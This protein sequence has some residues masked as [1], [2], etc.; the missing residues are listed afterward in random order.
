MS[1]QYSPQG[2]RVLPT[3]I[4]N[5]I[6]INVIFSLATFAFKR[7][8]GVDL[9]DYLGLY[10]FK[11]ENFHFFQYI[12]Y[13]FMHGDLTHLFFN[14]F[15]LWMFGSVL[16]NYWGPKRFLLFYFVTGVGAAVVHTI[17]IGIDY[18]GIQSAINTYAE[19]P[20]PEALVALVQNEL[21]A[22]L[23]PEKVAN[24]NAFLRE[25]QMNMHSGTDYGYQSV[26][27]AQQLLSARANIPV[28]GASGAVYGI[29][30]AF[31]MTF[32]NQYIY[33]YFIMP[34]KAKW[35]VLGYGLI[36]LASGIF[37]SGDGIAHF[38]HLGGMIFG[39]FL[40]RYWKKHDIERWDI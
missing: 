17:V 40:I 39:Y 22:I 38:A 1:N 11:S 19:N 3:I 26:E 12:T 23:T 5:L 4:K 35:F 29:L 15:S 31:G 30:L 6:I 18:F 14:M 9:T 8:F 25:W 21:T 10:F 28:V 33:L 16:E 37:S 20:N 24:V 36:E 32:P 34:I 7:T 27:L 2:F 13:M